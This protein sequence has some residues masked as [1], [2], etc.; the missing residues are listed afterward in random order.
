MDNKSFTL[1]FWTLNIF[2]RNSILII[3]RPIATRLFFFCAYHKSS[4]IRYPIL[5]YTIYRFMLKI[6]LKTKIS[7]R[8][9]PPGPA[10][11]DNIH[12]PGHEPLGQEEKNH[13]Q[14]HPVDD[15]RVGLQ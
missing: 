3:L 13:H 8:Q 12:Q 2:T 4:H 1:R 9:P 14:D 15:V 7:R 11:A 6:I 5:T 10:D